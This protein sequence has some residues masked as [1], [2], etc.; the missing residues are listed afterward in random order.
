MHA[1]KDASV[2]KL[3][4]LCEVRWN[5]FVNALESYLKSLPML[6][7]I[8]ESDKIHKTIQTSFQTI[9]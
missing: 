6:V 9:H 8:C 2:P 4:M 1:S 3:I 5:S 7:N